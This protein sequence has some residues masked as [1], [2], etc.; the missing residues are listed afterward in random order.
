MSHLIVQGLG[1][2]NWYVFGY[3]IYMLAVVFAN[4]GAGWTA[5]AMGFAAAD[6]GTKFATYQTQYL[7]LMTN[8]L[9]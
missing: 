8:I 3:F 4:I 9:F 2:R 1:I 6:W 5:F 7:T